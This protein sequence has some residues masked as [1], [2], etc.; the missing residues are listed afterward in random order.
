MQCNALQRR[1][2][3]RVVASTSGGSRMQKHNPK[4]EIHTSQRVVTPGNVQ[5]SLGLSAQSRPVAHPTPPP[6]HLPLL[7]RHGDQIEPFRPPPPPAADIDDTYEDDEIDPDV[8]DA[9]DRIETRAAGPPKP[10]KLAARDLVEDSPGHKTPI[11]NIAAQLGFH[12]RATRTAP[13]T[14]GQ[15]TSLHFL[16]PEKGKATSTLVPDIGLSPIRAHQHDFDF[17]WDSD[18]SEAF[19]A[20]LS[21]STGNPSGCQRAEYRTTHILSAQNISDHN[22]DSYR[23][24]LGMPSGATLQMRTTNKAS[25]GPHAVFEV[26]R[27]EVAA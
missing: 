11:S 1:G 3:G 24:F 5:F 17:T 25:H 8:L 14:A 13:S 20:K 2:R 10:A 4:K 18:E 12:S 6:P 26:F 21:C 22:K 7:S 19:R 15:Q 27:E 16:F 9:L 23:F